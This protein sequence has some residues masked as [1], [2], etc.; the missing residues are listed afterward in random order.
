MT[1]LP[2]DKYV[3]RASLI[4]ISILILAMCYV[5]T[6][7]PFSI[8]AI[9]QTPDTTHVHQ[10]YGK[11]TIT[12]RVTS[13]RDSLDAVEIW[14]DAEQLP[15][16]KT[17][18]LFRVQEADSTTDLRTISTSLE[19]V[20]VEGTEIL[21]FTIESITGL[22]NK[23]LDLVLEAPELR[24][25]TPLRIRYQTDA[26]LYPNG[27]SYT[28]TEAKQGN[29]GFVLYERPQL[30]ALFLRWFLHPG[31]R[32]GLIGAL[33][34]LG[35]GIAWCTYR[36]N[37]KIIPSSSWW[38]NAWGVFSWRMA[39]PWLII[40]S[41]SSCAVYWP[42][43]KM[44]FIQDDIVKLTRVKYFHDE[45][46]KL[47]FTNHL[48]TSPGNEFATPVV[49][50]RPLSFSFASLLLW[51]IA[52]MNPL[53]YHVSNIILLTLT[54]GLLFIL[55]IPLVKSYGLS[56]IATLAWLLHST[57]IELAYW[58]SQNEDLLANTFFIIGLL[59]Y[60]RWRATHTTKSFAMMIGAVAL[61]LLSKEHAVFFP[62]AIIVIELASPLLYSNPIA[63]VR[64]IRPALMGTIALCGIY[65]I[66]RTLAV[67][68]PSLPS[69]KGPDTSYETSISAPILQSI[70]GYA[71]W[72]AENWAWPSD[73]SLFKP[74]Q[75][76][77]KG[78]QRFIGKAEFIPPYY[79]G[80]LLILAY[81]SLLF[82]IRK[83]QDQYRIL[84]FAG[85]WWLLM[86]G[87][88]LLLIRAWNARWLSMSVWGI[89]ILIALLIQYFF[90]R[91]PTMQKVAM[92]ALS[93]SIVLYGYCLTHYSAKPKALLELSRNTE[94]ALEQFTAQAN[95]VYP[96]STIYFI[97]VPPDARGSINTQLL[98][99]G[100][101]RP[102]DHAVHSNTLPQG[103]G[104]HDIIIDM[105]D[106]Y[107]IDRV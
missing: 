44:F 105:R 35:V 91:R 14:V 64:H 95:R 9:T 71:A 69:A 90:V 77:E 68:D 11:E 37:K 57:K 82:S 43:T 54:A 19:D 67:S 16:I 38:Q 62:L 100:G 40:L 85:A 98:L 106:I 18:I 41:I 66:I 48:Y 84:L 21:H 36:T 30:I 4:G 32:G 12:Q 86:I 17:P 2:K 76:I 96:D 33:L 70:L 23:D 28:P 1:F 79:P 45:P 15:H 10:I 53:P 7:R 101:N 97:G 93:I 63:K 73:T 107:G 25:S 60:T 88:Q 34:I 103:P 39:L 6:K 102:F 49:F 87:P 83:H 5:G 3:R 22:Y 29:I 58:W 24:R 72:S 27:K 80:I 13:P 46:F 75:S 56:F 92:C 99:L 104:E 61:A 55:G 47:I 26:T 52:G 50:Y 81:I 78:L 74:L 51:N 31:H 8:V 65:L 20:L 59:M 89:G 42:A 94:R